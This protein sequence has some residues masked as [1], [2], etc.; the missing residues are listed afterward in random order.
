MLLISFNRGGY[1]QQT[2][3]TPC[4]LAP[5]NLSSIGF[6][7]VDVTFGRL[8]QLSARFLH[9]LGL[10]SCS[11]DLS[12]EVRPHIAPHICGKLRKVPGLA[13]RC[14]ARASARVDS[15]KSQAISCSFASCTVRDRTNDVRIAADPAFR[16]PCDALCDGATVQ[17]LVAAKI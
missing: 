13:V 7:L 4:V 3:L 17:R 5:G 6:S 11:Q 10:L 16:A 2:P 15:L 8:K 9:P 12:G 1:A 14:S